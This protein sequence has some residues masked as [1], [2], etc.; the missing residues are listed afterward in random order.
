MPAARSACGSRR[1]STTRGNRPSPRPAATAGGTS[2]P[3]RA[4]RTGAGRRPAQSPHRLADLAVD[5]SDLLALGFRP[6]PEL[7]RALDQLLSEVVDDPALNRR[8]WLEGRVRELLGQ[9]A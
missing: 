8:D 5:G 6:G 9:A 2:T 3:S 4:S 7:G 1:S